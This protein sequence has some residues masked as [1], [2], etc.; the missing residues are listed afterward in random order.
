MVLWTA[1]CLYTPILSRYDF[2]W[3]KLESPQFLMSVNAPS[4]A[5][6]GKI[7]PVHLTLS[8]VGTKRVA[9]ELLIPNAQSKNASHPPLIDVI[10]PTSP[11]AVPNAAEKKKVGKTAVPALPLANMNSMTD[12]DRSIDQKDAI[13]TQNP[14]NQGA[15]SES[16]P[17]SSLHTLLSSS[18]ALNS[19][20]GSDTGRNASRLRP[21]GRGGIPGQHRRSSSL[22][23]PLPPPRATVPAFKAPSAHPAV[24]RSVTFYLRNRE[25][26]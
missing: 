25:M 20:T 18:S 11:R 21:T 15:I 2:Q 8:N 3:P 22:D 24:L 26:C 6:L 10:L 14:E 12:N 13:N 9:L 23:N 19:A 16:G 17:S 4:P 7:F 1:S 5:P